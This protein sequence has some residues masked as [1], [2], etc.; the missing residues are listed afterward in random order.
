MFLGN[1]FEFE[2]QKNKMNDVAKKCGVRNFLSML[3]HYCTKVGYDV[4]DNNYTNFP[5][6]P[7]TLSCGSYTC[8]M[9]GVR[10][11]T[12]TVCPHPI[13]PVMRLSNIDTGIEKVKI[14]YSKGKGWKTL[15]TDRKTISAASKIV[16]LS[17]SGIAVT[18]ESAKALVKYFAKIEQLNMKLLPETECV[19]RLGWIDK[20]DEHLFSPYVEGISFDG[21][22]GYKKHYDSVKIK[23]DFAGWTELTKRVIRNNNVAARMVFAASL[24]SVLVKPLGCNCFWLHLWGETE[25]AKTVLA[26]VAASIWGNPEIGSF[27]HT[28]NSTFVGMEKTAAFYNNLPYILDELQI[29]NDKKD[30][31]N[32]IYML[33]EGS[34][35]SRG[36]K[37]GGLEAV[38]KW[39]NATITTGERP[40]VTARSG[41]GSVNRVLEIEC[42]E[43][44]F[45]DPR[46]VANFV[47][48]NYGAMGKLFIAYFQEKGF[49]HAEELFTSYQ[50]KLVAEYDIMQKQAQSAALI[51]TADTIAGELLYGEDTS[52]TVD[53]IAVYL[54]TK[55]DV[56]VNPRAYEYV[57]E[58]VATNQLHFIRSEERLIDMWGELRGD[59]VYIIKS[60]FTQICDE[61]GYNAQSLLSWL[62][63]KGLIERKNGKNTVT[64]KIL[65]VTTRCVHLSLPSESGDD[66]HDDIDF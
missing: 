24:A 64:K 26:M 55:D 62:A 16:D 40:I 59:E 30:L 44:F 32:L 53:D 56:S 27:I 61:G 12:D 65:G 11:D 50:K 20:D 28:F 45:T 33:T 14:A 25:S 9:L 10:S 19:T 47:K 42:K 58:Y 7:I 46:E 1:R 38:P 3:G 23:G 63:D 31:D 18:S 13:M 52:L 5:D 41:G 34:G 4:A 36:N 57:C 22:T 39:K 29:V 49:S 43:K 37:L 54:K 60:K 8:D 35:R 6:Q 2:Q 48:A 21:E 17:D 66:I 15:I 51:L